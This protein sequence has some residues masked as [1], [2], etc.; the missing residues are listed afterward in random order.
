MSQRPLVNVTMTLIMN[1]TMTLLIVNNSHKHINNECRNDV[2]WRIPTPCS[3]YVCVGRMLLVFW[4]LEFF[5]PI[6]LT[7]FFKRFLKRADINHQEYHA[8]FCAAFA[9]SVSYKVTVPA[10]NFHAA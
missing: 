10:C 2:I 6:S 1:V 7:A 5:F 3:K 8:E 4:L 9:A